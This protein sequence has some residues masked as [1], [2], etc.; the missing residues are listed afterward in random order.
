MKVG[1]LVRQRFEGRWDEVGLVI[2]YE[3]HVT[4][5]PGGMVLV[6]W[7]HAGANRQRGLIRSKYLEVLSEAQ[8][9]K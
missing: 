8:A 7:N 4:G 3:K 9:C 2:R 5:V 6:M 1:D